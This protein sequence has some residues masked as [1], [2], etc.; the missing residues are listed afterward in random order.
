MTFVL[1][2]RRRLRADAEQPPDRQR[3]ERR[4]DVLRPDHG[5]AVGLVHLGREL[6]EQLVV[7]D[8]DRGGE[9]RALADPLL[10]LARH[11]LAAAE[12]PAARGDVEKR[13]VERQPFDE[14]GELAEDLE[15]LR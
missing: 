3:I 4:G 8:A 11:L 1:E 2:P 15:D 10:D 12:E 5:E 6:R 7:R 13:L 14:V 9:S